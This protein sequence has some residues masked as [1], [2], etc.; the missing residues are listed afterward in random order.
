MELARRLTLSAT[1]LFAA[2]C[3]QEPSQGPP[4]KTSGGTPAE[5]DS[6]KTVKMEEKLT[7]KT[8]LVVYAAASTRDALQAIEPAYEHDHAVDLVFNFGSSGDLS[9][10]IVAA[11]KADVFLSADTKE[12][13]KVE[14]AKLVASGTRRDLL[15]N[16]LVVIEPADAPSAFTQPFTPAQLAD[17]RIKHLSLAHVESVPAGRYAKAWLEKTGQWAAVS[18]R[19]LPG[20]DVRAARGA[21]ESGGAEAGIV[22]KTDAAPSK[23]VRIVYAVPLADG[24]KITYPIAVVAGRPNEA[25]SRE[26]VAFLGSKEAEAAFEAQGFLIL[27][28][29]S[30]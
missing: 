12:M 9:K 5:S 11:A 4:P 16:Q 20:V 17:P 8:E 6:K 30:R 26:F 21:V 14:A 7:V 23:K 19:V 18:D 24:P 29:P 27:P 2:A 3:S 28:A 15:S 25:Q 13:D 10:Q 22:Y 1:L